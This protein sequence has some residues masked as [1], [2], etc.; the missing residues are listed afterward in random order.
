MESDR[1]KEFTTLFEKH[2]DELFRHCVLR[3]SDRERALD[4]TQETFLRA[5]KYA[6]NGTTIK[7]Y[8]SFLYRILNN[9]IIDEYRKWKTQSLDDLLENE[10]Y[11]DVAENELLRDPI[12]ALEDAMLRFDGERAMH[13]L[14]E[15]PEHYRSV[16]VLR[17]IDGLSPSEISNITGEN[18]NAVSVRIHRGLKKL[19]AILEKKP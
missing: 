9:L 2:A 15:L 3:I 10:E 18:E 4:I 7:N 13:A 8:R 14:E 5:L 12:D 16:I 17:Y 19:R 6:D 11:T 1:T